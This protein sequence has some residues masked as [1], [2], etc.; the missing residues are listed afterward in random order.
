MNK[1]LVSITSTSS[2]DGPPFRSKLYSRSDRK[3]KSP[4]L[5]LCYAACNAVCCLLS[6]IKVSPCG[7]LAGFEYLQPSLLGPILL[8]RNLARLLPLKPSTW[9]AACSGKCQFHPSLDMLLL[10][11]AEPFCSSLTPLRS[12]VSGLQQLSFQTPK[13]LS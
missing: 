2:A 3:P 9:E 11:L 6:C 7:I 12:T 10:V 5:C 8:N 13:Q 1:F 4:G